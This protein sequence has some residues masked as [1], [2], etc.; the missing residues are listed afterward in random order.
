[1]N[2]PV[3]GD[4]A[5][6]PLARDGLDAL[7]GFTSWDAAGHA[8]SQFQLSGLHCAAC[9]FTIQDVLARVPGVRAARVNAAS[10][11]LVLDWDPAQAS[12]EDV[13]TAIERAG[14]RA[15]PDVLESSQALRRAERRQMLWRVFVSNFVAMQV[16]MLVVPVYVAE[17]GDMPPDIERLLQWASWVLCLVMLL[18]SAGTFFK[19]A[20]QQLRSRR[21]GMDVPVALGLAVTFVASTGALFDPTG[22]LGH[23][24][25]FD[26]LSMFVAFLMLGRWFEMGA[27]H[28]A[29]LALESVASALPDRAQ[30]L[31][32]DGRLE[33]VHVAELRLGDRLHVPAGERFAADGVVEQGEGCV[34]EAILTGESQPLLKAVGAE[35]A[36]GSINLEAPLVVRITRVGA[37]TTAQG[38][39]RLMRD[40]QGQRVE[41][42]LVIDQVARGFTF[43]VLL[44]ALGAALAWTWWAPERAVAVAVA[45][46]IVTCPCAL[47][48]AAPAAWL[49]AAGAFARRGVMLVRLD[50]LERLTAVDLVVFD[51]TGTVSEDAPVLA[52]MTAVGAD[53]AVLQH[54]AASLARLS[55]HPYSRALAADDGA[56]EAWVDV[57]EHAGLGLEARDAAGQVWRLGSPAWV[58]AFAERAVA[59]GAQLAFGSP[60]ALL[61]LSLTERPR[62]G[63]L[64]AVAALRAQGCEVHLLSGD[65]P[66]AVERMA[67]Q[68]GGLPWVAGAT[69]ADKL[70]RVRAW[71]AQG[72]RVM[73]VGDGL[74]DAPVLAAADVRVVMG[75]G[76]GLARANADL[77][78]ISD[79]LTD[80][81]WARERGRLTQRVLRQNLGWALLYNLACVPLALAGWLPPLAAGIGMAASSVLVVANARRLARP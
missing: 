43:G 7:A 17:A 15:A 62:A 18:L 25:Y 9:A 60:Q 40:A 26:T 80:L 63:A 48:L 71:Q 70:A 20:V 46:L 2:S 78:L 81:P 38:I 29:A 44:L 50:V 10:A 16:M 30:R 27:R 6:A 69:P 45:V 55:R 14:Y 76:A 52:G 54:K 5:P 8:Q 72:R 49:A 4:A 64:E 13:T 47:T 33:T 12:L 59:P 56:L 68:L 41:Q 67:G 58:A 1:M 77:L 37:D 65:A 22:P 23:E 34:D 53:E 57:R 42:K 36:A 75:Q 79:R 11:R 3:P 21:L 73:M 24:V 51:K 61:S 32:A 74:N 35:V 31:A 19:A 28:R 66:A 39:V